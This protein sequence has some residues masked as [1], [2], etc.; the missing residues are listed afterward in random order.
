MR[1]SHSIRIGVLE[2]LIHLVK[3]VRE[4]YVTHRRSD[5][6]VQRV[7]VTSLISSPQIMPDPMI[8]ADRTSPT[9]CP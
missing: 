6:T 2:A 1:E 9:Y 8:E 4:G 7:K 5:S 3:C